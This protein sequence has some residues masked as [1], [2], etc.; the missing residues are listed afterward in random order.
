[1]RFV[2]PMAGDNQRALLREPPWQR[3]GCP[4]CRCRSVDGQSH[5]AI[6]A[7]DAVLVASGTATLEVALFK[8]PMVIAY[9]MMAL[10][11]S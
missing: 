5:T 1:M 3:P 9:K 2:V 11:G 10:P 7:A 4:T 8:K 6:A